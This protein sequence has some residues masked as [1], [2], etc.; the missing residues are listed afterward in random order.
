MKNDVQMSIR[1]LSISSDV[2]RISKFV[3]NVSDLYQSNHAL[4]FRHIRIDLYKRH[5]DLLAVDER[6]C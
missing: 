1:S 4:L 5:T 6:A 2:F 3:D